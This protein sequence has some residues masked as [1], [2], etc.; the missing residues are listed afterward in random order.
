MLFILPMLALAGA[1]WV[2]GNLGSLIA[3][4]LPLAGYV[5]PVGGLGEGLFTLWLLIMGVKTAKWRAQA[6]QG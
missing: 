4:S 3:P 5:I 1:G 2:A 6:G